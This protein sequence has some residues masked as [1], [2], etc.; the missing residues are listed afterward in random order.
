MS[1]A[2]VE[3]RGVTKRYGQVEALKDAH[4]ALEPGRFLVLLGPSGSGKTT[5]L[6]C[7]AGIEKLSGGEI[8]IGGRLVSAA[9]THVSPDKR[10]LGMVFQDFALWPHMTVA[11]NV[12]F[13]LRRR[14]LSKPDAARRSKEMLDKVGLGSYGERY[15]H[16][17]SGGQQQ[18]VALARALVA[19]PGLLLFDEPLSALDA[20]L[21]ERLR[22]EIGALSREHGAT[23]VYITHD[24]AEAFALGDEIGV[25]E[26]GNLVQVGPPEAIYRTPATPFIARFTGIGAALH[27]RL[28]TAPREYPGEGTVLIQSTDLGRQLKMSAT[29]VAPLAPGAA[30]QVILRPPATRIIRRDAR[31]AMLRTVVRDGAYHGRGYFYVLRAGDG[32]EFTGVFDRRR[33]ERG[34]H[35]D[36]YIDPAGALVFAADATAPAPPLAA[37]AIVGGGEDT[38]TDRTLKPTLRA[39]EGM[40]ASIAMP[41]VG[42]GDR[43]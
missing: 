13:P 14:S 9:R 6:R 40:T 4:V 17:L 43:R 41:A 42:R 8:S 1:A 3:L 26:D 2:A 36:I 21:R 31:A 34:D 30:V 15:P 32:L 24:Q 33:F 18:R 35:V 20:N 25:L 28:L 38:G 11:Q 22:V 7:L 5:L 29:V 10:D 27:G 39:P 23:A 12:A 16:E 19:R 37:D